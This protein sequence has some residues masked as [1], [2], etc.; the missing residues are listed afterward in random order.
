[1]GEK[2]GSIQA[3]MNTVAWNISQN[4]IKQKGNCNK[5]TI[6]SNLI[7]CLL[8]LNYS[9]IHGPSGKFTC[10]WHCANLTTWR[11][12]LSLSRMAFND[13]TIS[14]RWHHSSCF[15]F[16]SSECF[17]RMLNISASNF[18]L[19][20]SSSGLK[21]CWILFSSIIDHHRI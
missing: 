15:S 6:S 2:V 11:G 19:L 18:M 8:D 16:S 10:V 12:I 20:A 4:Y 14:F 21:W 9:F 7:Y 5:V 1:M 17:I 13:F 3:H